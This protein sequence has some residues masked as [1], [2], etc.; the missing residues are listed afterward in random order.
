M[1]EPK[2]SG[3]TPTTPREAAGLLAATADLRTG[4]RRHMDGARVALF[5]CGLLA[6]AAVPIG[7]YA[8]NFGAHGRYLG[9][10]PAFAYS[11]LIGLCVE[12]TPGQP[13]LEGEFDGAV[14]RCL[15]WGS[16]FLVLP[17]AWFLFARWYRRRGEERG[18]VP[19]RRA[20]TVVTAVL[21][22][23]FGFVVLWIAFGADLGFTSSPSLVDRILDYASSPWYLMGA[24]LLVLGVVER[25]RTAVLTGLV[26]TLLLTAYLAADWGTGLVP[27]TRPEH[28]EWLDGPQAKA[29]LLALVLLAGAAVAWAAPVRGGGRA[30]RGADRL[31]P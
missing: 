29:L 18:I 31:D 3:T 24:G 13:C 26:H 5:G 7:R 11:E 9:S 22:G 4:A 6:L 1:G 8:Y 17:L 19:R 12:H 21:S 28:P 10:Y 2:L 20:W 16:W 23:M 25:S 14:L 30:A 27:W 15:A